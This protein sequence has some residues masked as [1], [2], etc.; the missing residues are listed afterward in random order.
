MIFESLVPNSV[1]VFRER[2]ETVRRNG[3]DSGKQK[4]NC[5]LY[6]KVFGLI[7]S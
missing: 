6:V 7:K 3:F 5:A 1:G 4:L 2:E